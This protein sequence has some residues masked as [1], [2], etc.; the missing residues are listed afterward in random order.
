MDRQGIP[1]VRRIT[2]DLPEHV[3]TDISDFRDTSAETADELR[4]ALSVPKTWTCMKAWRKPALGGRR[5]WRGSV[6]SITRSS[7][8]ELTPWQACQ[9]AHLLIAAARKKIRDSSERM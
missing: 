5:Y 7:A 2:K 4:P 1:N 6:G 9:I 3:G 8:A